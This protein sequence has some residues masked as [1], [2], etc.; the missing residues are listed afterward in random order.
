MDGLD[1]GIQAEVQPDRFSSAKWPSSP[2]CALSTLYQQ[3]DKS[4]PLRMGSREGALTP[5]PGAQ[6]NNCL[7]EACLH[8]P[9]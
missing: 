5:Y 3:I 6:H 4:S 7:W 9:I 2:P 1:L 8:V